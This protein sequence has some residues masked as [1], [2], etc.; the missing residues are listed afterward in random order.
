MLL[1]LFVLVLALAYA[2]YFCF[3]CGERHALNSLSRP[4]PRFEQPVADAEALAA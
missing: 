4:L 3:L 1:R 2:C